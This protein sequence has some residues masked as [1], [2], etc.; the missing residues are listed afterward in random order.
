VLD[1][2]LAPFFMNKNIKK[3]SIVA[4]VVGS[5]VYLDNPVAWG[6]ALVL[7]FLYQDFQN[8]HQELVS[9][10]TEKEM[11]VRLVDGMTALTNLCKNAFDH[12][13]T[14]KQLIDKTNAKI[15]ELSTGLHRIE[16][17]K[18]AMA[19][20]RGKQREM[21]NQSEESKRVVREIEALTQNFRRTDRRG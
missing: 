20:T 4:F 2:I 9:L 11:G 15:G 21:E 1:I 3:Y 8:K 10:S 13:K 14:N 12:I 7:M 17:S 19:S 5:C 16:Q 18:R 6:M